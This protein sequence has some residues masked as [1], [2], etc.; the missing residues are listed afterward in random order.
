M[1]NL[2]EYLNQIW[3][4][5]SHPVG[6]SGVAK[7]YDHVRQRFPNAGFQRVKSWLLRQ[8]LYR[9]YKQVRRKFL[10]TPVVGYYKDQLWQAD[11]AD[12][13]NIARHNDGHTFI[14]VAI[15][16]LSRYAFA[17]PVRQK[18]SKAVGDAFR[19][20]FQRSGRYPKTLETDAGKEFVGPAIRKVYEEFGIHHRKRHPK[21]KAALAE[22]LIRTIKEKMYK[23]MAHHN[24]RRWLERLQDF[25]FAYNNSKH[26]MLK[27]RPVDVEGK[28]KERQ[29]FENLY[30]PFFDRELPKKFPYQVGDIVQKAKIKG[31]MARGTTPTFTTGLYRI[32]AIK[33]KPPR[34][35]YILE[36]QYGDI[37][38][39][40][41]YS[42]QLV[43]V[44][45]A[46]RKDVSNKR[47]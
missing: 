21:L 12:V 26:R 37:V 41:Y 42:N 2:E 16:A 8:P 15:D 35:K 7:L 33:K 43:L 27:M 11:L 31:P 45:R 30:R 34:E 17:E 46:N 24:T 18:T 1:D 25:V 10:R 47:Q 32:A 19:R 6:F 14:L 38:S 9:R 39:P 4:T 40:S 28:E 44:E 36:N 5:A 20:I 13:K 3:Y 23:W 22:R 29:A